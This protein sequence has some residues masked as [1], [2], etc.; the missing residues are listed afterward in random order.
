[1]ATSQQ[2]ITTI[3]EKQAEQE[4]KE[5]DIPSAQDLAIAFWL[6]QKAAGAI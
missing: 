1:M 3:E 2:P 5:S 6:F 4:E